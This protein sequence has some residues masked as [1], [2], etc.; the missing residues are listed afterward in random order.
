MKA[1]LESIATH[2]TYALLR[3]MQGSPAETYSWPLDVRLTAK[4]LHEW[5]ARLLVAAEKL[6]DKLPSG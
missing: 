6:D 1:R 5:A 3:V 2:T 4:E